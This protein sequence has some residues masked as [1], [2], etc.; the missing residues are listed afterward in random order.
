MLVSRLALNLSLNS[1]SV[2]PPPEV[3]LLSISLGATFS[4][5]WNQNKYGYGSSVMYLQWSVTCP[6]SAAA[7]SSGCSSLSSALHSTKTKYLHNEKSGG[8]KH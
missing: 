3:S 8:V 6:P 2:D 4:F 5:C 1:L 7:I